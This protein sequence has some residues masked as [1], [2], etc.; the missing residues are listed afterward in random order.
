MSPS[1]ARSLASIASAAALLAAPPADGGTC[2]PRPA[3]PAED[4]SL[5]PSP[6]GPAVDALERYAFARDDADPRRRELR[7]DGL[8]IVRGGRIAWE[9]Y[10]RAYG[11]SSRHA[12][13]SIAKALTVALAGVAAERRALDLDSSIC[14]HLPAP[15]THC[16]ITPRHLL[17][18]ASGI[19]WSEGYEGS[20]PRSSSVLAMLYGEGSRDMT[21]F[22]LAH[23]R[24][25]PPGKAWRYSS[26]DS[27]LLASVVG[28][29]LQ[30]RFGPEWPERALLEPL[31]M[32]SAVLERDGAGTPV[33]SSWL[34]AT[35]RDLARLGLLYLDDG[36]WRGSRLLPEGWVRASTSVSAPLRAGGPSRAPGDVQGWG[37]WLNRPV[38]SLGQPAPWA[39]VPEDAYAARGHWGQLVAVI[40]SLDLVV[41]RTADDR[42][43]GALDVAKLLR[44]AADVGR[45]R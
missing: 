26:G 34:H 6:R 17:E 9:R 44:L 5:A 30:P 35:P 23:A 4:W 20:P 28:R 43:E 38:P 39:G 32:E 1:V 31:G 7:T 19:E 27:V 18:S 2:R 11:P 13:W 37:W 24:S 16:G 25:A 42:E 3:G 15:P 21:S 12:A 8:V 41:V 29:A 33:G 22:V 14:R 40:P 36:C 10:A 45:G